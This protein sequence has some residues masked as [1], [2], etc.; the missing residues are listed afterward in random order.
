MARKKVFSIGNALSQGLEETLVSAQQFASELRVDVIPIRKLE[1]DPDNPRQLALTLADLA[2]GIAVQDADFAR[3]QIELASLES[4]AASIRTQGIINPIT[5]Y[6]HGE[7]YRLIA[8]ERRTLA[9]VLAKKTDIQAKIL[10]EKP[11]RL[12]IS[13]LQWIENMERSDLTLWERLGN[14]EKILQARAEAQGRSHRDITVTELSQLIGCVKS[15]AMNYRS[16]LLADKSLRQLIAE[17]K[18]RNLEK[19]ALLADIGLPALRQQATDAC[20]AGATLNQLRKLV[21]QGST[22]LTTLPKPVERRGRQTTRVNLG[23]TLSLPA[24]RALITAMLA[25]PALAQRPPLDIDWT[26]PRAV[27]TTFRQLLKTLEQ[28]HSKEGR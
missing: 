17:N 16:L 22:K 7:H 25:Q 8:G 20:V 12:K 27:S 19:A 9:S 10:D 24:A 26:N 6:K 11:D 15:H 14:L 3:K 2:T 21:D 5:V 1:L 28:L 18:I 13:L 4:L 23:S